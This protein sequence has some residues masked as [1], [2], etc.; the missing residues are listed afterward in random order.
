[1][2]KLR[3]VLFFLAF[4]RYSGT[5][6]NAETSTYIKDED[7][8][9]ASENRKD[10][11]RSYKLGPLPNRKYDKSCAISTPMKEKIVSF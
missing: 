3:Y 6:V 11:Q 9:Y 10:S 8:P 5:S 1:M 7:Y 2:N 4:E